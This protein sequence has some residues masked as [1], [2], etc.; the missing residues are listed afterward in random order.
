MKRTNEG[1]W[2]VYVDPKLRPTVK[3]LAAASNQKVGE[4]VSEILE[5]E[6]MTPQEVK[7]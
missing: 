6:L 5:K 2:H 3:I 1:K 7:L 4:F